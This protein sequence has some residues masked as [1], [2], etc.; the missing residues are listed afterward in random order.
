MNNYPTTLTRAKRINK[1]VLAA[2]A[3]RKLNG[4]SAYYRRITKLADKIYRIAYGV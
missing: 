1:L 2:N 3:E 4:R